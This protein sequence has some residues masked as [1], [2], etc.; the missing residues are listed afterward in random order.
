M[1]GMGK[2]T[3]GR[4]RTGTRTR[5]GGRSSAAQGRAKG[6]APS[7]APAGRALGDPKPAADRIDE[8]IAELRAS[9][10]GAWRGDVLARVRSVIL[11][12]APGVVEEWKWD[13]PVWSI[14]RPPGK[15]GA[16][17][18]PAIICTGETYKSVVKLTFASGAALRDP[19]GLFNSSLEG[20][21]RRALDIRESDRIN[22]KALR[23]LVREA[24]ALAAPAATKERKTPTS[25]RAAAAGGD[26][27]AK[28]GPVRLLS[29]GNPQIAKG[30]GAGPVRAY[31][32]AMPGW[33]RWKREV[34]ER[35]D[36]LIERHIPRLRKA[37]KWNSPFYGVEGEP[38]RGWF[39]SFHCF[40]K[41]IKVAGAS[42]DPRPPG[43]SANRAARY[44]DVHEH[45]PLDEAQLSAWMKQAA[46]L[47]GWSG[48][49]R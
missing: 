26:A 22:E 5:S 27:H 17:G 20:R 36:A 9:G 39:A 13:V 15:S 14:A 38:F 10:V 49:A 16:A 35:L 18:K 23:A 11:Q 24:A 30:E 21:T 3:V 32:A 44:L 31:I 7:Q 48:S 42:L 6:R 47:P 40:E 1:R 2:K 34:G 45:E 33:K 37:V 43:K 4:K 19:A 8:R 41:Y 12:A 46:K 28:A 25:K 29:G